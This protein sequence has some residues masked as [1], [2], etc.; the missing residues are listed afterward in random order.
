M[1]PSQ[2]CCSHDHDCEAE[3]CGASFSLYKYVDTYAVRKEVSVRIEKWRKC[4]RNSS[5][6]RHLVA[7]LWP[8]FAASINNATDDSVCMCVYALLS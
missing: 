5:E 3:D 1:P 2:G 6:T 7:T 4:E 8:A